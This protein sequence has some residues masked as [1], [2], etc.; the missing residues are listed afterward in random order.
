[1][2]AQFRQGVSHCNSSNFDIHWLTA[3]KSLC[4]RE[5]Y[6]VR[7][8]CRVHQSQFSIWATNYIEDIPTNI[9]RIR[10][11]VLLVFFPTERHMR[12]AKPMNNITVWKKNRYLSPSSSVPAQQLTGMMAQRPA[13][14]RK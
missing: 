7:P 1:M 6:T 12:Q 5:Q 11:T 3:D 8:I 10:S 2:R 4:G 9:I 13:T 14:S